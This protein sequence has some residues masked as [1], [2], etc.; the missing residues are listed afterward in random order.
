[1]IAIVAALFVTVAAQAASI[2]WA[3]NGVNAVKNRAGVGVGSGWIVYLVNADYMEG[4]GTAITAGTF[5]SSTAGVLG[6]ATTGAMSYLEETA[7]A[8]HSSLVA[9]TGYNYAVLV[10]NEVYTGMENST[11]FYHFSAILPASGTVPAYQLGE[12]PATQVSFTSPNMAANPWTA[13]TIIPEPTAMALLALGAAAVGLR[14][15]FR[16]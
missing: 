1:M 10:F 9:G 11:G 12:D 8:T 15:R 6:S 5:G 13:Y 3:I 14:R 4:I 7:T 2:D 16:K